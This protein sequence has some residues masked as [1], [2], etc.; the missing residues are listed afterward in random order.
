MS[1]ILAKKVNISGILRVM[2][3]LRHLGV[4]WHY[5]GN[6]EKAQKKVLVCE[7]TDVTVFMVDPGNGHMA[8]YLQDLQLFR[9]F[10]IS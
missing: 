8:A 3:A 10:E 5:I 7:S 4:K 9:T 6:F 2:M 1:H